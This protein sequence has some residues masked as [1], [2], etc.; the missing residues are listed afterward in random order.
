MQSDARQRKY[1][2]IVFTHHKCA[3][4]WLMSVL[5][6][7]CAEYD[8]AMFVTHRSWQQPP[9]EK[10]FDLLLFLNGDYHFSVRTYQEILNSRAEP[11]LHVIR[12]PLDILVSAYY[13]HLTTHPVEKWPEL[14]HQREIL[15]RL[16]K[17]AGMLA[18]WV[19]LE[20][21]DF[22]NGVIGPLCALRRWNFNDHR[23]KTVRMEDLVRDEDLARAEMQTL[24]G[25]D[26]REFIEQA[27]FKKLSGG[28]Q[29][30]MTNDLHHY[31]SGES[32]QW[33]SEMDLSL[34]RAI[35]ETY[36]PLIDRFYPEV[37]GLLA[38]GDPH[39]T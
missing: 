33:L 14:V 8:R 25:A 13:S 19:F 27:S 18:T 34:A 9:P 37:E 26:L 2:S 15:R 17:Q 21:S 28:R 12:N 24:F 38:D 5:K 32:H 11:A 23:I 3:S 30:G 20:R 22:D 31:R 10:R 35:Y 36:K 39:L 29:V 1:P 6:A 16:D 4:T 7:G